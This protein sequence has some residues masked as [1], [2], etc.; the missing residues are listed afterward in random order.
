MLGIIVC[1]DNPVHAENT[2][3]VLTRCVGTEGVNIALC[4]SVGEMEKH[5]SAKGCPDIVLMDIELPDENGVDAVLRLFE[6]KP[7]TQIIFVT[8]YYKYCTS[9]YDAR[10]VC[11]L[12]KPVKEE[13]LKKAIEMAAAKRRDA[14]DGVVSVRTS[15]AVRVLPVREIIYAE[16][17]RRDSV[18]HTVKGDVAAAQTLTELAAEPLGSFI[19]CHKSFL[20]NPEAVTAMKQQSFVM[21][22]G[23]EVPMSRQ[24]ANYAREAFLQYIKLRA[25]K[26]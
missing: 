4:R 22:D 17:S 10:H 12:L 24:R 14:E 11:F 18:I 26:K 25:I 23:S 20:I 19:H 9:V 13:E 15:G 2:L 16:S 7:L 5:I 8:G 3:S 6:D 1:E 21:S